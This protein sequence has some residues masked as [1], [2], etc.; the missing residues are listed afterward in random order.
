MQGL[1]SPLLKHL[2]RPSSAVARS[3]R[4]D[5]RTV[6]LAEPEK[7]NLLFVSNCKVVVRYFKLLQMIIFL[8]ASTLSIL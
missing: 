3:I 4:E 8:I 7:S 1:V 6:V 2:A 5:H